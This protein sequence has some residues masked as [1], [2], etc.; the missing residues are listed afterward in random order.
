ML[1]VRL[2]IQDALSCYIAGAALSRKALY[3]ATLFGIPLW[4]VNCCLGCMARS[5]RH[6]RLV[7]NCY[8]MLEASLANHADEFQ[9]W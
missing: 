4:I 3:A 1:H 2:Q 7:L 5:M 9:A 6:A 8:R